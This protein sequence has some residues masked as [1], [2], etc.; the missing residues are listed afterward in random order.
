MRAPASTMPP[1]RGRP[2]HG[3]QER[4]ALEAIASEFALL[5][6]RRARLERQLAL[7]G[8][9]AEAAAGNLARVERRM[10]ALGPR[11]QLPAGAVPLPKALPRRAARGALLEY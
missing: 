9:Q 7:L 11:M 10:A 4:H 2:A 1:R 5:A 8:R 6:Q 3:G